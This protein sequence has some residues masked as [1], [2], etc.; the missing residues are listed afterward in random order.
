MS[1]L[2]KLNFNNHDFYFTKT[3]TAQL[4][5]DEIFSDNYH[6]LRSRLQFNPGDIIVDLGANEGMFSIMMAKLFPVLKVFAIEPI[7]T[8]YKTFLANI[9]FN[10]VSNIHPMNCGVGGKVDDYTFVVCNEFSGGSSAMMKVFDEKTHYIQAA[11]VFTLDTLFEMLEID[12]CKLLKIDIEGME[13]EALLATSMLPK[14]NYVVGEIHINNLL[15]SK[16]YNTV[17]LVKY[18]SSK[19]NLLYYDTCRMAE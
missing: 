1:N 11:H 19:T 9:G 13:H 12:H 16:G 3:P 18:I 14:I 6:V 2:I 7:N 17:D 4:L 8:T 10:K 5:I 15:S